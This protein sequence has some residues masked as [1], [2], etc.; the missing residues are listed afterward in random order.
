MA[1]VELVG[2]AIGVVLP[3]VVD[4]EVAAVNARHQQQVVEEVANGERHI[5]QSA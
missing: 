3:E 5:A 4:D 1:D 2:L